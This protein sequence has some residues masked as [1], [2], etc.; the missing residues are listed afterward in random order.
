VRG[1]G[2]LVLLV[3]LPTNAGA[4]LPQPLHAPAPEYPHWAIGSGISTEVDV[5]AQIQP[6]G[7][8]RDIEIVPYD[9]SN[10]LLTAEMRASFDSATVRA[11]RG[12]TFTPGT[13]DGKVVSMGFEFGVRFEDP[14]ERAAADSSSAASQAQIV[15][16]VSRSPVLLR[17]ESPEWPAATPYVCHGHLVIQVE[18]DASG[19]TGGAR[20]IQRFIECPEGMEAAVESAALRAARHWR[21]RPAEVEAETVSS[22]VPIVFQIP[23]PRTDGSVIVGCIRDSVSGRP[24]PHGR[25][26]SPD[27]AV[28][29]EAD[30]TGWFVLAASSSHHRAPRALRGL[31]A[32]YEGGLREVRPWRE[33]GDEISLLVGVNHCAPD[34][35]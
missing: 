17:R 26:A 34:P 32:C 21:Y 13:R 4:R 9:A 15:R 3:L 23:S 14:A 16:E 1:A 35:R 7:R 18:V 27:G 24:R 5:R 22:L 11:V 33:P 12:W 29:G 2:V 25:I 31:T 20:V 19:R 10:D 6:D 30:E 28:I 8:A